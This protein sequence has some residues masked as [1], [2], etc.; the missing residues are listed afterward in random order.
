L[1]TG[2]RFS[3]QLAIKDWRRGIREAHS[4]GDAAVTTE[5]IE[6]PDLHDHLLKGLYEA[7]LSP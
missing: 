6:D 4:L 2:T 5:L 7:H 1:R 3:K